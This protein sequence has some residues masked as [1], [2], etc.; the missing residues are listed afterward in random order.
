MRKGE[1]SKNRIVETA[2]KLFA[3]KGFEETSVQDILDEL[4]L[5]K[6]GF[7]H[8]FATKMELL[9]EVCRK[10]SEEW[11]SRG[12]AYVRSLRTGPAERLN[13][14]LKLVNLMDRDNPALLGVLTEMGAKGEDAAVRRELRAI[15]MEKLLPLVEEILEAGMREKQFALRRPGETARLITLL[16]LDINEEAA[17]EVIAD[18]R[19]PDCA[20]QVLELLS[21][22]REAVETLV[23]APY[24][25]MELF[26]ASEMILS[27]SRIAAKLAVEA[28]TKGR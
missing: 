15:A 12:A 25:S 6:G 14:A 27:V 2:E 23:N 20:Y 9:T 22:Y 28:D 7:Y 10:R 24:G 11:Y 1:E 3:E 4:K 21:A 16:A 19:N 18:F 26:D 13:A 17:R 5:S 8:Y